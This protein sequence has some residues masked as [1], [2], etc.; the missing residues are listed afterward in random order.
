MT[1]E[2]RLTAIETRL[3]AIEDRHTSNDERRAQ[4]KA[5]DQRRALQLR[6][7]GLMEQDERYMA[8]ISAVADGEIPIA[9]ARAEADKIREEIAA[10]VIPR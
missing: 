2:D 9:A 8:L 3:A 10:G 5:E 4:D 7:Y 6:I 1:I